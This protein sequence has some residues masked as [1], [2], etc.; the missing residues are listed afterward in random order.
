MRLSTP[1]DLD[2][3]ALETVSKLIDCQLTGLMGN[4]NLIKLTAMGHFIDAKNLAKDDKN[5]AEVFG[6]L[7]A[8]ER[9]LKYYLEHLDS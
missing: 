7:C 3:Q 1:K 2:E 5:A 8:C 4:I 6:N 9:L